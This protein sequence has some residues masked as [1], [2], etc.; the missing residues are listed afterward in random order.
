MPWACRS[1][2]INAPPAGRR[3]RRPS[4]YSNSDWLPSTI[5]RFRL[6][7]SYKRTDIVASECITIP[8]AAV[9]L[10][11]PELLYFSHKTHYS[12]S[13]DKTHYFPHTTPTED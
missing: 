1:P 7:A 9:R 11:V 10:A 12:I 3:C 6:A 13:S 5:S 2:R 4:F 8:P